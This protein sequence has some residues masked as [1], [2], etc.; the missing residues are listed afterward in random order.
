MVSRDPN[1]PWDKTLIAYEYMNRDILW[2]KSCEHAKRFKQYETLKNAFMVLGEA[3]IGEFLE[4]FL[5]PV[6]EKNHRKNSAE[7]RHEKI[8]NKNE[9]SR[10]SIFSSLFLMESIF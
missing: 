4:I 9:R 3:K 7:E 10:V 6:F 8:T 2:E 1:R 5:K